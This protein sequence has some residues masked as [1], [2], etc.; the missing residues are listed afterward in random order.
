MWTS[1]K[2]E[3]Q[4]N[5]ALPFCTQTSKTWLPAFRNKSIH[6]KSEHFLFGH[7]WQNGAKT[8]P[9][10]GR[11]RTSSIQ[12]ISMFSCCMNVCR[13]V[14]YILCWN[15]AQCRVFCLVQTKSVQILSACVLILFCS[16]NTDISHLQAVLLNVAN[17]SHR[18]LIAYRTTVARH[19]G[20]WGTITTR[21]PPS[22]LKLEIIPTAPAQRQYLHAQERLC[23]LRPIFQSFPDVAIASKGGYK[24]NKHSLIKNRSLSI[25]Q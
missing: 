11:K 23:V 17:Q 18:I 7:V 25:L 8:W 20:G 15:L 9:P 1:W 4:Q 24:Q 2:Q 3:A 10:R 12:I 22:K 21:V 19:V 16:Q 5:L 14:K 13:F 6:A